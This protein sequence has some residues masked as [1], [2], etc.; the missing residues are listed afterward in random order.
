MPAES[1]ET[2]A[3]MP[4]PDGQHDA[5]TPTDPADDLKT[6]LQELMHDLRRADAASGL[7]LTG[8]A[9]DLQRAIAARNVLRSFAPRARLASKGV[10]QRKL[11]T[12]AILSRKRSF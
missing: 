6:S 12:S 10:A 7:P 2:S 8:A 5:L 11:L 9:A 4:T 3:G 1:D